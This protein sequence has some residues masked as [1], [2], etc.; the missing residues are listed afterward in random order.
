MKKKYEQHPDANPKGFAK[1]VEEKPNPII[2]IYFLVTTSNMDW[3]RGQSIGEAL[4]KAK[5]I[6]GGRKKI[7]RGMKVHVT[8][9]VIRESN[10]YS[11]AIKEEFARQGITLD[12]Y[13]EGDILPPFVDNYGGHRGVGEF[14]RLDLDPSQEWFGIDSD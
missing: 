3:A 1:L 11:E 4:K 14:Q 12:G 7:K 13:E 8:E 10:R 2:G 5:A 9:W 6:A